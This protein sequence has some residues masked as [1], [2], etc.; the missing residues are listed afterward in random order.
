[1]RIFRIN[2]C[3]R[4]GLSTC[5]LTK[6]YIYFICIVGQSYKCILGTSLPN[7]YQQQPCQ[8]FGISYGK[9][10]LHHENLH[11]RNCKLELSSPQRVS[12]PPP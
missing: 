8:W 2:K 3:E 4:K 9:D 12:T 7:P 5:A 10:Y 1:M 11:C 6:T